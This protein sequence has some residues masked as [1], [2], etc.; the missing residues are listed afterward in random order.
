MNN[1]EIIFLICPSKLMS[2]HL[3]NCL[4]CSDGT[5]VFALSRNYLYYPFLFG[6][7]LNCLNQLAHLQ[8]LIRVF[9]IHFNASVY[10]TQNTDTLKYW[11]KTTDG[12]VVQIII[13]L[14][15]YFLSTSII[16]D[17]LVQF[18]WLD[19]W[20]TCYYMSFSTVFHSYQDNGRVKRRLSAMEP[21]L[22]LKRF[23]ASSSLKS[24]R[25]RS[26]KTPS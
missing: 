15:C 10:L 23:S 4:D 5:Q 1:L 17:C 16:F 18:K 6:A 22:E 3:K 7:L 19:G 13:V 12:Q 11:H 14:I 2:W 24:R 9:A 25:T 20:M 8:I 26:A 21:C